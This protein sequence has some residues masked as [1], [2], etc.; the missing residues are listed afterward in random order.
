MCASL[1]FVDTSP[2]SS[3]W[4]PQTNNNKVTQG[5]VQTFSSASS[6]EPQKRQTSQGALPHIQLLLAGL[7]IGSELELDF[8]RSCRDE[9][10]TDSLHSHAPDHGAHSPMQ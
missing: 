1:G 10:A 4:P 8:F 6:L 3:S 7:P 2:L 9:S 5:I